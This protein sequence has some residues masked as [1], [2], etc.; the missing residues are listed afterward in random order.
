ML[1][2]TLSHAVN[3]VV[4]TIIPILML[5]DVPAMRA[6]FGPDSPARRI[7]ACLY[8]T[9]ALAS[10]AALAAQAA[11]IPA[12]S[13]LIACVLFPLQ[14]IYKFATLPVV[15]W[16][17]PVVKSNLAIALLHAATLTVLW[18]SGSLLSVTSH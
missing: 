11:A 10:A 16:A 1:L 4:V 18:Q 14:I 15:G 3:V 8:G 9:I 7:L 6:S 17:N 2:L 12:L 13:I 5:R